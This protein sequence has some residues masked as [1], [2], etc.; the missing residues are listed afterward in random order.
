M[1]VKDYKYVTVSASVLRD[2]ENSLKGQFRAHLKW[3]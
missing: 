2:K 1:I 3:N